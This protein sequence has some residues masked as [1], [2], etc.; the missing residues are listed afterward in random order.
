VPSV[1]QTATPACWVAP[2]LASLLGQSGTFPHVNAATYS[3]R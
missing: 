3:N 2:P 1:T